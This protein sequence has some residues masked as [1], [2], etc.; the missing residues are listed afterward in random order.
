MGFHSLNRCLLNTY[1]VA[2]VVLGWGIQEV[3][4]QRNSCLLEQTFQ[5]LLLSSLLFILPFTAAVM[6]FSEI[7]EQCKRFTESS[8]SCC[9]FTLAL[10]T[11]DPAGVRRDRFHVGVSPNP[12]DPSLPGSSDHS[13]PELFCFPLWLTLSLSPCF[14]G[15]CITVF[16]YWGPSLMAFL[17]RIQNGSKPA[18]FFSRI[19]C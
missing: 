1:Y 7:Q 14:M 8:L 19:C 13:F 2:G 3:T 12:S 10:H 6:G 15:I 4:R 5:W 17:G 18:L 9:G 11:L 16:L